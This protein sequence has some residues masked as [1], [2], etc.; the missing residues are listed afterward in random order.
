MRDL[1]YQLKQMCQRNRDGSYSTQANRSRMLNQIANQLQEMGYRRM[2]TRSLKPKHVDALV[3]RWLSEGM[4]PGTIK[5]RMNCLRWWAAKVDRRNVIARSNEFY[6]IPDRQFVSNDSK[7]VAVDDNALSSVKDDHVRMSLELQRAFGL[8]REEAIKFMPGYADQGDHVRL[9]ASWTK[10]GKARAVPVL[11]Q[12]Q[13]A[14]LNRAHRLVGSGSLI[15]PQKKY[16]QQLRTYE[17]HTTQAG[18]SKLHG[19]RHA[20]AQS[21]YQ[22]LTGWACPAARG[23]AAKSLSAEQRQQDHQARLTI[24]RELG[25]VRE[26]ISAVYLGR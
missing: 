7:A 8:R 10:G 12:E 14:V 25:H 26:Q 13:R 23:P 16:I 17:R 9:K 15:P 3:R 4:A 22:A 20:Y 18:L 6:G 19:L 1:N 24:S 11:T 21:R 2:T 5:N